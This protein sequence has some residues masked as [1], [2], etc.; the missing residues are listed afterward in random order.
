MSTLNEKLKINQYSIKILFKIDL[1]S[2]CKKEKLQ[3]TQNRKYKN[4][5]RY[6][7][8]NK[9]KQDQQQR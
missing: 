9:E 1:N 2:K 7:G 6:F 5:Y 4:Y 3:R 8:W